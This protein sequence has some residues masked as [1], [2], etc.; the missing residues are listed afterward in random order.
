MIATVRAWS[1]PSALIP[2]GPPKE[3]PSHGYKERANDSFRAGCA[4][5]HE[6][7]RGWREDCPHDQA[8]FLISLLGRVL[9]NRQPNAVGCA[10]Q[11]GVKRHGRYGTFESGGAPC[12]LTP[13]DH[14]FGRQ[15]RR[16]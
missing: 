13:G 4:K 2:N 15:F 1:L 7:E 9:T 12:V 5:K 11:L 6:H 3:R 8:T 16:N 14:L 10:A